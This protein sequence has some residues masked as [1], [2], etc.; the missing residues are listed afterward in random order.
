MPVCSQKLG[1]IVDGE[2]GLCHPRVRT[3]GRYVAKNACDG[4]WGVVRARQ[5]SQNSRRKWAYTVTTKRETQQMLG[6]STSERDG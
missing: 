6:Y 4:R 3:G 5:Y 2:L 1:K